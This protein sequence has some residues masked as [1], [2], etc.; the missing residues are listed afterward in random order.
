MDIVRFYND[1]YQRDAAVLESL[2]T[3]FKFRV[4]SKT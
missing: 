1:I 2:N 4:P 3:P